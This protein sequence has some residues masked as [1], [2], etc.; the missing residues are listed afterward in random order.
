MAKFE[1]SEQKKAVDDIFGALGQKQNAV[2]AAFYCVNNKCDRYG[3][4]T[5][6][7]VAS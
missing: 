6:V 5:K 3:L 1:V 2:P 4:L 7:A